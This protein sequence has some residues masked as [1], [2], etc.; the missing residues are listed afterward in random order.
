MPRYYCPYCLPGNSLIS[1]D[2]HD[3]Y[4]CSFCGEKLERVPF[5]KS[6]QIISVVVVV[7][8]LSPLLVFLLNAVKENNLNLPIQNDDLLTL[9]SFEK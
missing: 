2:S 4:S 1:K 5:I 3:D 8:L 7:G 6:T 9:L